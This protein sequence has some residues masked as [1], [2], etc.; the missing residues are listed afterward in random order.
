MSKCLNYLV[1]MPHDFAILLA[2]AMYRSRPSAW[3]CFQSVAHC[4]AEEVAE[5]VRDEIG[6]ISR[7]SVY[8]ALATL[9]DKGLVRRIQPAGSAA[10]YEENRVGTIT[11]I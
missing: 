2:N 4:T 11:T 6:A 7:Q 3:Q 5:D 9:T 1:L 10:L 8:D